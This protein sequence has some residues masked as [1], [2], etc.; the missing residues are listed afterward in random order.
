MGAEH[1]ADQVHAETAEEIA[2][3]SYIQEMKEKRFKNE[4]RYWIGAD[5]E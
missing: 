5:D 3:E 4:M 1:K 2:L